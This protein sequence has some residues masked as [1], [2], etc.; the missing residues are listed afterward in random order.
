MGASGEDQRGEQTDTAIPEF[1][2]KVVE[3]ADTCC[4]KKGDGT[5]KIELRLCDITKLLDTK[6]FERRDHQPESKDGF[7]P[8]TAVGLAIPKHPP[9]IF[10]DHLHRDLA[11]MGFPRVPKWGG[12]EIRDVEDGCKE[13]QSEGNPDQKDGMGGYVCGGYSQLL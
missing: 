3:E 8:E 7:G 2:D 12:S 10:P 6:G 13:D 4:A 1:A 11:V 9:A 5:A